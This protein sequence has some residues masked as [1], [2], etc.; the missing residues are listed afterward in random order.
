MSP[1]TEIAQNAGFGSHSNTFIGEQ[2][3]YHGLST[4]DAVTMAFDIF[5]QH[6]PQFKEEAL[7]DL[8]T[9]VTQEL[10]NMKSKSI[11]PP[12]PRIAVNTLQVASIADEA[13]VRRMYAKLLASSMNSN[14]SNQAHPA[15]PKIIDQMSG[16][17]AMLM[18]KIVDIKDS[19][20]V[21]HITF[22]FDDKYLTSVMP[23]YYSPYFAD[24]NDHWA[25]SFAIENLS[26]HNLINLFNGT[27]KSYDYGALK[28]DPFILE[29][30]EFAKKYNPSRNLS[31]VVNEYVIQPNDFGKQFAKACIPD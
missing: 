20:P 10:E 25:T 12:S 9:M 11:D 24:M 31:I 8:R 14:T 26:R 19:I 2:N 28:A 4:T 15:F 22:T 7:R 13:N 6:F 30:F 23:H 18:K 17:D 27:V 21:G 29:R 1:S 16:Y 5:R 3:I